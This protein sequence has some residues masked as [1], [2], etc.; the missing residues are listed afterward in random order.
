[1]TLKEKNSADLANSQ[2]K[3]VGEFSNSFRTSQLNNLVS[4]E[5]ITIPED[6]QVFERKIGRGDDARTAQYIN[7]PTNTGRVAQFYPTA[8]ARIA[9]EVDDS[10]KNILDENGRMKVVR[11]Q[12]TVCD[13]IDGKAIDATMKAL[14]G[15]QIEYKELDRVKT[16]AFGVEEAVATAKDVTK[17]IIGSWNFYGEKRPVDYVSK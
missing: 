14:K 8:M 7:V 6:Y 3:A 10:G 2:V 12:G 17:T 9:F 1:M 4:G 11:S 15:C 5:I 13:Y 16:R